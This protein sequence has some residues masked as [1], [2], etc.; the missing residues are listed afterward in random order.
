M[1][2]GRQQ[3]EDKQK[4]LARGEPGSKKDQKNSSAAEK[5]DRMEETPI[6]LLDVNLG[7]KVER[8][9]LYSGDEDCLEQ[10]AK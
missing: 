7:S 6:L 8:L 3:W 9:T 10:V 1:R 4:F 5:D 2:K